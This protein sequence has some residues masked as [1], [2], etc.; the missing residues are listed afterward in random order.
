M[1]DIP[2]IR[3]IG[4][5]EVL[6]VIG[7][8]G[9]SVVFRGRDPT[10]GQL[11]A[12]KLANPLVAEDS[13]LAQRFIREHS[14]A[15]GLSHP[16]LVEVYKHGLEGEDNYL[17]M[18]LVEGIDLRQRV[19]QNG[20]MSVLQIRPIFRQVFDVVGY[21]HSVGIIHRDIKPA[22]VLLTD[23]GRVKLADLGLLKTNC[24]DLITGSK[25]GMGTLDFA[26]PEQF[27]DA[28]RA[29]ARCDVYSLAATMYA[30]LT[31]RRPFG[32]GGYMEVIARKL[33]DK[34]RPLKDLV[35]GIDPVFADLIGR[36]MHPDPDRRPSSIEEFRKLFDEAAASAGPEPPPVSETATNFA[37]DLDELASADNQIKEANKEPPPK[38]PQ[39]K[40]QEAASDSDLKGDPKDDSKKEVVQV[41]ERIADVFGGTL[42]PAP[43]PAISPPDDRR[44]LPRFPINV[45]VC[46]EPMSRTATP[47]TVATI[48]DISQGGVCLK[49]H[50]Y[51]S[52]GTVLKLWVPADSQGD[53]EPL[54]VRVAW[55]KTLPES[56]FHA[57]C[58]FLK[59]IAAGQLER[60]L[61]LEAKNKSSG[62]A[63]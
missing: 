41:A 63:I 47:R 35:P 13:V 40:P 62:L 1:S 33:G 4:G 57:G 25:I 61:Y 22:N 12:I 7:R 8:G 50:R 6:N 34:F 53:L 37:L 59:P 58:A 14:I 11:V 52:S 23:A 29:D 28:K 42:Q 24:V 38:S 43:V 21:L 55:N 26:A 3:T 18:E 15:A 44:V 51:T 17:I 32:D 45:A 46:V 56:T 5:F 16:G 54:I 31:D 39:E 9:M 19:R 30:V 48:V 60:I 2:N 49:F 20:A 36:S 10:T 27:D